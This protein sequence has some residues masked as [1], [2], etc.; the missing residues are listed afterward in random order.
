MAVGQQF[1]H[2]SDLVK[3]W[4][5]SRNKF[6]NNLNSLLAI[7]RPSF[8]SKLVLFVVQKVELYNHQSRAALEFATTIS[9][10]FNFYVNNTFDC[11]GSL[12]QNIVDFNANFGVPLRLPT[13]PAAS[14][15]IKVYH[16]KRH[17]LN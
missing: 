15:V 17:L 4:Q 12:F 5:T 10:L 8:L 11:V 1:F 13:S 3:I 14:P 6:K 7:G 2:L 9:P 16:V